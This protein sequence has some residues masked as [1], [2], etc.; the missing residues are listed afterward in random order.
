MMEEEKNPLEGGRE[1]KLESFKNELKEIIPEESGEKLKFLK[2]EEIKTMQKDIKDLRE[3]EAEEEKEKIA[4]LKKEKGQKKPKEP[5]SRP[6]P[7]LEKKRDDKILK[8]IEALERAEALSK[9]RER[10]ESLEKSEIIKKERE[11]IE[12]LESEE[13]KNKALQE[14]EFMEKVERARRER[15]EKELSER[16]KVLS[17]KKKEAGILEEQ[18]QE[19]EPKPEPEIVPEKEN[20]FREGLIPKPPKK[21]SSFKKILIRI[22]FVSSAVLA[23][24]FIYWII[25][26]GKENIETNLPQEQEES[27]EEIGQEEKPDIKEEPEF[28]IPSS[29]IQV[30]KNIT[31]NIFDNEEIPSLIN[32]SGQTALENIFTRIVIKNE[33]ENRLLNLEDIAQSFQ[34][35]TMPEVMEKLQ[36]EDFNFLIYP[37]EQG[38]RKVIIV[39]IK[40]REN[41]DI[42]LKSWEEKITNDGLFILNKKI[43]TIG[44]SFK[45]H[46]LKD[47]S[48]IRY[49]TVSKDDL[50]ICYAFLGNYLILS[51]SF[52]SIEKA[53]L[54]LKAISPDFLNKIG[55]LFVVGF[56]GKTV[57]P[58]LEEFFKKYKPGGILL[59]SKNIESKEQLK[60]LTTKLQALSMKE[61]GLPL[62]IA[63]DQ[64]GGDVSRISFLEE[65]TSQADIKDT[66]GAYNVGLERGQELKE[67]GINLNLAPLLDDMQ[68]GDFYF[69]R[70]FQKSPELSGELAKSLILGQKDAGILTAIKHFPGYVGVPFDPE[71]KLA[72]ISVPEISQFQKA[73]EA[74]PELIMASNAIYTDIDPSRPFIFSQRSVLYLKTILGMDALV[75]SD[76]LSQDSLLNNFELE[77]IVTKP[78]QSGVD[79]LFFS[80][81]STPAN[82][83]IDAFL[84]KVEDKE[85][86]ETRINE[87]FLKITKLK[88]NL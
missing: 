10:I 27:Q 3:T 83:A 37:Q 86:S 36:E 48:S 22:I 18:E 29:F 16:T 76:D 80:G 88:E 51:N 20:L 26:F 35:E 4:A 61:T 31:I 71:A 53:I 41:L 52:E 30:A 63:V 33:A 2:R 39:K 25:N 75:I 81:L 42:V 14:I 77:E 9:E 57:T 72:T 87:I 73:M 46:T 66:D 1:K 11:R 40:D 50:G 62:L 45:N 84:K 65:K 70:S 69:N 5:A 32:Q 67:L 59:L 47:G 8:E 85:I 34:I 13:G 24:I 68:E 6:K 49:L 17:E 19:P 23:I 64:E 54:E 43:A 44:A 15:K 58:E 55:Q 21:P 78:V 7:E 60:S 82:Q 74:D 79:I 38:E 12:F 56:N 28:A